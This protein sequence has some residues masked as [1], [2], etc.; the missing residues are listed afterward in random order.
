MRLIVCSY[1]LVTPQIADA[2]QIK[3]FDYSSIS[4]LLKND[5][6]LHVQVA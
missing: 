4:E 1:Y 3:L 2:N 6:N 5:A